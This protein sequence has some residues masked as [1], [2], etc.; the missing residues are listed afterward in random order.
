MSS[1]LTNHYFNNYNAKNEQRLVEDLIV[2]SIKIMGFGAFYIPIF[3]PEDRDILFGEDPLKKFKSAYPIEMYLSNAL[4]YD[5]DRDYFSKFGLEIRNEAS[6]IVSRRSFSQR[7]PSDIIRPREGDLVYVPVINGVGNLFEIT[8]TDHT[9]DFFMLGRKVPYFYELKLE[10][11][12]FSQDVID[13]GIEEIDSVVQDVAYTVDLH[14]GTGTGN[15]QM[16]E[17]VFQSPDGTYA[18]CTSY[19]SVQNWNLPTKTLSVTY[20]K[21]EF[22]DGEDVIGQTSEASYILNNYNMLD[23]VVKNDTYDNDF[24]NTQGSDVTDTSESNPFGLI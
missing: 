5:G 10:Q 2:E 20:I 9:K 16:R 18:N 13:T 24:I 23:V 8:F 6:V 3:N 4:Q 22:I 12:R 17:I 15:Y 21:G 19:A 1:G 7:V 14:M 11:Y